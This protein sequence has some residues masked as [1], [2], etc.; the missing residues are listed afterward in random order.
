V[1]RIEWQ[2]AAGFFTNEDVSV[3][4]FKLT[5]FCAASRE[6]GMART[7]V[8]G[9]IILT[10]RLIRIIT[11]KGCGTFRQLE[12]AVRDLVPQNELLFYRTDQF[13]GENPAMPAEDI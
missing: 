2:H 7:R 4:S 11:R 12:D 13:M 10:E 9:I 5:E 8:E 6:I 3:K 1:F